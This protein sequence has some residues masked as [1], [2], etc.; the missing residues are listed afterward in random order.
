MRRETLKVL[1]EGFAFPEGPRWHEGSLWFSDMYGLAVLRV[2]LSGVS[3][4]VVEVP[5]QPSGLGWLPD[6]RLLVVS[7]EDRKVLRLDPG[8]LVE[9][10]DLSGVAPAHCNDM[11][12]DRQGRAY[13]GNFGSELRRDEPPAPAKLALAY[14]D[15]RVIAV[16][17]DLRFANGMAITPDG[18]TLFVAESMSVPPRV[19]AFD[20]DPEGHLTNRRS[21]AE[22]E[23]EAP[24][25]ICLD[26]EGAVWIASP[27]TKEAA[28]VLDGQVVE[29]VSTGEHGCY[30]VALGGPD[31]HTLFICTSGTSLG[32]KARRRRTGRI[33]MVEVDVP[34][35]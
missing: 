35:A 5:H 28:R 7:M 27:P 8:G 33:S 10:A 2:D 9:H 11:V 15:G 16:A 30:A 17:D 21:V 4:T 3:E 18:R 20:I 26:A 24:D 25:G 19:T 31:G 23:S 6:G 14:T 29:R 22:F 1:A 13:V 12:V 32:E 34:A